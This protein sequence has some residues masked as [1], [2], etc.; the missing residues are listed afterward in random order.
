MPQQLEKPKQFNL[1]EIHDEN[2][3]LVRG[4]GSV[5]VVD[6][7]GQR[8]PMDEFKKVMPIYMRRGGVI[9]DMHSNKVV[10]KCLN[11]EF[12]TNPATGA[13]G[14]YLTVDVFNDYVYDDMVWEKIKTREYKGFSFG[15]IN[16]MKDIVFE[17]GM[18]PEVILKGLECFEFAFVDGPMNA[19]SLLDEINYIAKSDNEKKEADVKKGLKELVKQDN[20][21]AICMARV[22][23]EDK[24]KFESCVLQVKEEMGISAKSQE[25]TDDKKEI[26]DQ[27]KNLS[28]LLKSDKVIKSFIN[29]SIHGILKMEDTKKIGEEQ[30]PLSLESLAQE[31]AQIKDALGK[32]IEMQG[33]AAPAPVAEG[34]VKADDEDKKDEKEDDVKKEEVKKAGAEGVAVTLPKEPTEKIQDMDPAEGAK[35]DEVNFVEKAIKDGIGEV[36]KSMESQ[37]EDIK[38]SLG[39]TKTSTPR[40]G[41]EDVKKAEFKEPATWAEANKLAKEIKRRNPGVII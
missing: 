40:A 39:L 15:G 2:S 7:A 32:L 22:G 26:T 38:K 25:V 37:L 16:K 3:R 24:E 17:E 19:P 12:G 30:T 21:W 10:A 5:D 36:Q 11:Y 14:V 29:N 28:D 13:E 6:K 33:Q 27:T 35:N 1:L 23:D 8:L 4:W 41:I 9:T 31:V 34:I 20:P 18:N